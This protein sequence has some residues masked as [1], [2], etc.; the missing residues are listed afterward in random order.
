MVHYTALNSYCT[1]AD[2]PITWVANVRMNDEDSVEKDDNDTEAQV[3]ERWS[4][5]ETLM[6]I[7]RSEND[8][9]GL[10]PLKPPDLHPK[11]LLYFETSTDGHNR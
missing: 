3:V 9:V 8:S 5:E 11:P 6:R 7:I 1:V 4:L 2:T 10:Y